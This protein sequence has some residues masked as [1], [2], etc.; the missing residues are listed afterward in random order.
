MENNIKPVE[1]WVDTNALLKHL[2]ISRAKF[3]QLILE[4]LP[5]M[6]IDA[7]RRFRISEV[8]EWLKNRNQQ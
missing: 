4:G 2:K 5:M 3:E 8:E 7:L 6:R 1:P